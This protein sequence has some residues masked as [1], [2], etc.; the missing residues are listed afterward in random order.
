MKYCNNCRQFVE[1]Q[2][3]FNWAIFIFL[4]FCTGPCVVFYLIYYLIENKKCP[5]CNSENW[6]SPP[7]KEAMSPNMRNVSTGTIPDF[8]TSEIRFC[9]DCGAKITLPATFCSSCGA[10][11]WIFF[12]LILNYGRKIKKDKERNFDTPNVTKIIIISR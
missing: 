12:F 10:K 9:S 5:M 6:G 7:Q 4:L 1:P 2:R 3:E 11:L 8:K